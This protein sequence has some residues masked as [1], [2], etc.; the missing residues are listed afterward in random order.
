MDV[1]KF[2]NCCQISRWHTDSF[3]VDNKFQRSKQSVALELISSTQ[4]KLFALEDY[5]STTVFTFTAQALG[6]LFIAN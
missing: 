4:Q 2:L 6:Y 5:I 3:T 1:I